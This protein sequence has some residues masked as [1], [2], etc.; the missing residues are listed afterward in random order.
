MLSK[1]YDDEIEIK[2]FKGNSALRR[3]LTKCNNNEI[4]SISSGLPL[5]GEK[6]L[7]IE[8]VKNEKMLRALLKKNLNKEIH[9]STKSSIDFMYKLLED[10]YNSGIPYDVTQMRNEIL[11]FAVNSTNQS[12]YCVKRVR[13]MHFKSDQLPAS[14][15][16][17]AYSEDEIIF[18]DVEIYPNLFII[19]W[20]SLT[21]D[22]TVTMINPTSAEVEELLKFKIA[23][24]NCRRYDNHILYGSY[25]GY[26]QDSL[27]KL[28]QAIIN[29]SR[30]ATFAEAYGLSYIDIYEMATKKQSLKKWEVELGL[31]HVEMDLP[32]DQPVPEELWPKVASYCVNDVKATKA[33]FLHLK[34]DYIARQI[35]AELSGRPVNDTTQ[36][37][38]AAIIF[39]KD[40]NPQKEF[41]YTDLSIEF[42]GYKYERGK[43]TYRGEAVSEG[44]QVFSKPGMYG[45]VGLF[46]IASQHPTTGKILNIFGKYTQN[47]VML[48]DSRL[49]IKHKE[50]E[51]GVSILADI[52]GRVRNISKK[53]AVSMIYAILDKYKID[54]DKLAYALKIVINIVYGMTSAKFDNPFKDPRNKD[55]I[56]AKRGALFMVDLRHAVEEQ[57]YNVIHIKTDSIKVADADEFIANFI[58]EFGMKYGYT[59]EHEATYEK[60]CIVN[61]AVYIAQDKKDLSWHA[62]GAQF[63]HPYVFKRLFSDEKIEFDDLCEIKS[64]STKL[65]LDMNED[66]LPPNHEEMLKTH[67]KL[68]RKL[69]RSQWSDPNEKNYISKVDALAMEDEITE[70]ARVLGEAHNYHFIGKVGKFAPIKP[71]CGGGLLLREKDGNYYKANG[72]GDY[73]WLEASMILEFGKEKD[74]DTQYHEE[75]ATKAIEAIEKYGDNAWFRSNERYTKEDNGIWPF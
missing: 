24:Y 30:N 39:G 41:V 37:H 31:P 35:I 7:D 69:E 13:D 74:I 20:E 3:K 8:V 47:Y 12:D 44:G 27:Y 19:C 29:N 34:E 70:Y 67:D 42:P 1:I 11:A 43:S 54:I 64:V 22:K 66:I 48:T 57:G 71:G 16:N 45:N 75:L 60:L 9:P 72:S 68:V 40:R 63:A 21:S 17:E 10:A 4:A 38:A 59:F 55:N 18:L 32:W 36:N 49:A 26:T 51:E 23:G 14:S 52:I 58:F 28:S 33:V 2:V 56:M 61:D 5:K 53:E 15:I 50:I 46:D 73:R 6:M 62:T 25:I 65:F